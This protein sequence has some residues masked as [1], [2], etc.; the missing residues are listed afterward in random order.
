[1]ISVGAD[2]TLR[3][4]AGSALAALV[5]TIDGTS[6][7]AADSTLSISSGAEVQS[8]DVAAQGGVAVRGVCIA[9]DGAHALCGCSNGEVMVL[10]TVRAESGVDAAQSLIHFACLR[11]GWCML[12]RMQCGPQIAQSWSSKTCEIARASG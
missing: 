12:G 6:P 3:C 2:G 8:G 5:A 10:N 4:W 7:P 11:R 1:M 9:G